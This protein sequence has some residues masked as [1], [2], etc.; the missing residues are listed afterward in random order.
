VIISSP[1]LRRRLIWG[2]GLLLVVSAVSALVV[3]GRSSDPEVVESAIRAP[4]WE[5]AQ[6]P[7]SLKRSAAQLEEPLAV[8]AR[9]LSTAVA[10][11][12]VGSS[13]ELVTPEL[14]QGY[15]RARWSKG[16]IPVVPFPVRSARWDLD[17]SY[18]NE[19]G[20]RVAVFP[21]PGSKMRA[22]VFNLDLRAL[23]PS[24]KRRWLVSGFTPVGVTGA[25]VAGSAPKSSLG[26]ARR[27]ERRGEARLSAAWLFVPLGILGLALLIPVALG[28][29]YWVRSKQAE[30]EWARGSVGLLDRRELDELVRVVDGDAAR[31][32]RQA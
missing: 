13:W 3:T 27:S 29:S 7:A 20:L 21:L 9:F 15:T 25:A 19:V 11:K 6:P 4:G 24:G 30:R 22:T 10:R 18:S 17:Y 31:D 1:R 32:Q 5:P 8:A 23:G 2:A 14:R 12:N 28:V 16:D 26:D